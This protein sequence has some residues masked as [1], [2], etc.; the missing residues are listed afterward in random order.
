MKSMEKQLSTGHSVIVFPEGTR[1]TP[2]E[3]ARFKTGVGMLAAA[4][5]DI[6]IVPVFLLGPERVF[7]KATRVPVP[8]WNEVTVGPPQ[9]LTG[10]R[11][12][13]TEALEQS[14]HE[15]SESAVVNRH[16]RRG[17]AKPP[18]TVAVLGI[19]G[20]GKSTLA[21]AIAQDLAATSSACLVTDSLEFYQHGGRK[22]MQPLPGESLREAF[23]KHAKKARSLKHYKVPKIIELLL[24][25][26]I[27]GEVARWYSPEYIVL[28]GCP[29]MNLAAWATLYKGDLF[30]AETCC[31]ALRVL[32]GR[33]DT[34]ARN[35]PI[36]TK[37]PELTALR[38]LRLTSMKLPDAVLMLDVDPSVSIAR[39]EGRGEHRQVHE[40]EEKLSKLREGYRLVC[41]VVRTEF[42]IPTKILVGGDTVR[43]LADTSIGFVGGSM[44]TET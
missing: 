35:D 36:F 38:R 15:L 43:A 34:I 37:F 10:G 12:D 16:R 9:V 32:T 5:P 24:R 33:C 31:T 25:D 17:S 1:G 4:H 11:R 26:H 20:S 3:M 18:F 41:E 39:I 28:D 8:L 13:I 2:G 19:D 27:M 42:D 30:D 6:P 40:T 22:E 7:P 14:L 44:A 29:L 23:G 21:R